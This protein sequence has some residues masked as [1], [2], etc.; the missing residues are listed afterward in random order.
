M[1]IRN[2]KAGCSR[3]GSLPASFAERGMKEFARVIRTT[4]VQWESARRTGLLQGLDP[5]LKLLFL[6]SYAVLVT[7]RSSVA[8]H[9]LMGLMVFVL[10]I[11]SVVSLVAFYRRVF[12]LG[13]LFGFV[14]T[15][16]SALNIFNNGNVIL[17]VWKLSQS[18][19]F[20]IYHI[21][22][23]IGFTDTGLMNVLILTLRVINTVSLTFL[24]LFTTPFTEIIR[25]LKV[26]G[27]PDAFLM[28]LALT[29]KYIFLFSKTVEDMHLAKKSRTLFP[30]SSAESR[31]WITGRIA[32][33]FLKTKQRYEGIFKAMQAR[34]FSGDFMLHGF[35]AFQA[36][37]WV[38]GLCFFLFGV[39]FLWL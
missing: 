28:V 21:P 6:I 8:A 4:F 26:M 2:L 12:L 16:P 38:A 17:P 19:T 23:E 39:I 25:A 24:I 35:G 7:T 13:F 32:H 29:Y 27:V 9:L 33:L 34:G 31:R 3:F 22:P 36:S 15:I 11:L 30:S 1:E 18:Y 10:A 37:D 14:V 5:R 20:L